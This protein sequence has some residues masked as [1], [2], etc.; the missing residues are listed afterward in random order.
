[1]LAHMA[2]NLGAACCCAC[3]QSLDRL[4][5][6]W[7]KYV[8]SGACR[9]P[10]HVEAPEGRAAWVPGRF[11]GQNLSYRIIILLSTWQRP[12]IEA[13]CCLCRLQVVKRSTAAHDRQDFGDAGREFYDFFWG[14]FAD[15]YIEAAKARLYGSNIQAAAQT[16][17]VGSEGQMPL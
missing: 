4:L 13:C 16:R 5:V 14:E 2:I 12:V 6:S 10:L 3:R 15:W 17:Q 8:R 1:M 9:L 7:C 11:W